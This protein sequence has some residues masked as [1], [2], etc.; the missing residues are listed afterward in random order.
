MSVLEAIPRLAFA[1]LQHLIA[2]TELLFEE[3]AEAARCIRR[4]AIGVAIAAATG[5]IALELACLWIIAATWNGPN[6]LTALGSL[7]IAFALIAV[8]S[9]AYASG[10]RGVGRGRLFE[11]VREEWR[12]DVQELTALD[13]RPA[14]SEAGASRGAHRARNGD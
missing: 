8:I 14:G 1:V 3:G 9:T 12:R 5:F 10:A 13:A 4:A 6:R 7:C 2:Y 11:G